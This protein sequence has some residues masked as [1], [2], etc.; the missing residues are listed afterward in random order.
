MPYSGSSFFRLRL[1][2]LAP[3]VVSALLL[4]AVAGGATASTRAIQAGIP[5]LTW[6]VPAD[7]PVPRLHTLGRSRNS[8]RCVPRHGAARQYDAQGHLTPDLASSFSTP[9]PTTYV[10]NLRKGR[11]ILG[12]PAPHDGRCHLLAPA[13]CEHEERLAARNVLRQRQVDDGD[14]AKPS[15]DQAEG[16]ESLLPLLVG[17]HADR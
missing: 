13:V 4:A 3:L 2:R 12:R 6:G 17:S 10:Y 8:E 7:D 1:P 14:R 5:Q 9:N 11:D 16:A 15:D